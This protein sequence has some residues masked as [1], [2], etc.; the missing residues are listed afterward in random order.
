MR[1]KEEFNFYNSMEKLGGLWSK[2]IMNRLMRSMKE[3]RWQYLKV[4]SKQCLSSGSKPKLRKKTLFLWTHLKIK[5]SDSYLGMLEKKILSY[6]I[7]R[8]MATAFPVPVFPSRHQPF[9]GVQEVRLAGGGWAGGR[10]L[11]GFGRATPLQTGMAPQ[12]G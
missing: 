11:N 1:N 4:I 8:A 10:W 2:S 6:E 3:V 5:Q 12:H 9:W 7:K